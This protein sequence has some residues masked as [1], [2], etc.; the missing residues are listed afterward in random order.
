MSELH[1]MKMSTPIWNFRR[2]KLCFN[3]VTSN[4]DAKLATQTANLVFFKVAMVSKTIR[5]AAWGTA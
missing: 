1:F 3:N 4:I 2:L 5:I